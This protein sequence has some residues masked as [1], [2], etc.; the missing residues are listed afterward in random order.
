MTLRRLLEECL[1]KANGD[2]A[3]ARVEALRR[4]HEDSELRESIA[5]EAWT[6]AIVSALRT[7]TA[8]VRQGAAP[9]RQSRP[10]DVSGLREIARA[11]ATGAYGFPI[12]PGVSLGKATRADLEIY[13]RHA[14]E[15]A[16]TWGDRAEWIG[17]IL[18]RMP[19]IEH[20]V[21]RVADVLSEDELRE[22]MPRGLALE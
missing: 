16:K 21:V 10:D 7:V 4:L 17:R 5:E 15:N 6:L 1:E 2:T 13:A 19:D 12:L 3:K 9:A 18:Q 22:L 20:R 11:S 8:N 14:A